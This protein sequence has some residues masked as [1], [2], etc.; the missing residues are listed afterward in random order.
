MQTPPRIGFDNLSEGLKRELE[1][2]VRRLGYLGEFFQVAAHQPEAL[3]H[4]IRFTETLKGA[5]PI[6]LVELLAL[7]IST[8]SGNGYERVQHERLALKSGLSEGWVR[9]VER[10][11]PDGATDLSDMERAAQRLA[12]GMARDQGRGNKPEADAFLALTDPA[13]LM[14]VMLT[15]G[16]YLAHAAICNTLEIKAPVSSPIDGTS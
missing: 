13:T 15:V 2:K 7:T 6:N 11:S 5:L 1:P 14:G 3:E 16:R 4:F 8:L 10:L 12:L 9:A